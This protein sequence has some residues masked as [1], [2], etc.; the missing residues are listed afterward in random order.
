MEAGAFKS[1]YI[2]TTT[3]NVTRNADALT[4]AEAGNVVEAVGSAFAEIQINSATRA[5]YGWVIDGGNCRVLFR[6]SGT[7]AGVRDGTN[8]LYE[9]GTWTDES[10]HRVASAWSSTLTTMRVVRD[11]EAVASA[12][13]DGLMEAAGTYAIGG[14]I[15]GGYEMFGH[16]KN[17]RIWIRALTDA[18]MVSV[19][20][21]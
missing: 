6:G 21:P 16:I 11:G 17:L 19:T 4:F 3:D 14:A 7:N 13:F 9:A 15:G 2:P 5:D 12:A 18:E 1:S 10:A 20:T 8:T